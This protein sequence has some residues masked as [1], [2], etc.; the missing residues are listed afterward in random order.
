LDDSRATHSHDPIDL[1]FEKSKARGLRAGGGLQPCQVSVRDGSQA[2]SR[3]AA[4]RKLGV[5]W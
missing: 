1:S 4:F 3:G 2:F 5:V